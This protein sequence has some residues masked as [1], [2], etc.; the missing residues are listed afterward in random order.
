M[1]RRGRGS[2]GS[3]PFEYHPPVLPPPQPNPAP[4]GEVSQT[5]QTQ[6]SI[7]APDVNGVVIHA[8]VSIEDR[9]TNVS[10]KQGQWEFR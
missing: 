7:L 5:L 1:I 4:G 9:E 10:G 3:I 2:Y 6:R 8:L